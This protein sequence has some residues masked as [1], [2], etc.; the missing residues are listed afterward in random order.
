MPLCNVARGE[1]SVPVGGTDVRLCVTLGALAALEGHF[2]VA[3]FEALGERLK[4]LGAADLMV[5]LKALAM[6]EVPEG[7]GF[8]EAIR[9]VVKAFEAMN[10]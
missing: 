9:A 10:G 6:D 7:V 8:S 4:V 5:V 3:G 1:V 2:G